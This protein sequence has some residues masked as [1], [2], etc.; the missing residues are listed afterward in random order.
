MIQ[1]YPVRIF[2]QKIK[3]LG[4]DH[5]LGILWT[6]QKSRPAQSFRILF[7]GGSGKVWNLD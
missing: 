2:L 7:G 1:N 5:I 4:Q 6:A 3:G